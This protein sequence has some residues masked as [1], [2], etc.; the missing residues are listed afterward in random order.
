VI[1]VANT[2]V[3]VNG[4][5]VGNTGNGMNAA[6]TGK[7][8]IIGSPNDN[9][10]S[11]EWFTGDIDEVRLWNIALTQAQIKETI[12][13][14]PAANASGLVAWYSFNDGA[15]PGLTN[16][17]T[18][19]SGVDGTLASG[20]VWSNSPVQFSGNA[21]SLDGINDYAL[22]PWAAAHDLTN[23]VT[24]EAWVYP[25]NNNWDNILMKGNY[26]YGFALSGSGGAGSCGSSGTLVYW[27]QSQ[28]GNTIRSSL[29]YSLNTWQ[30]VAVTVEDIGSQLQIYF[31]LNGVQDGPYF[32]AATA[33]SNGGAGS[34]IYIGAQGL[35]LG[36]YFAGNLDELR[37]WNVVRPQSQ[38]QAAMNNELDPASQS[39]LVAYY[40]FNQGI[41]AGTNNGFSTIID[42]KGNNNAVLLNFALSGSSSNYVS[43]DNSVEI[44]PIRWQYFDAQKQGNGVLL[45]WA[46]SY[47]NNS[48]DYIVQH[49][50]DAGA[51]I[52]I[53]RVIAAGNSN[54]A[55]YYNFTHGTPVDGIN[56]YR[57]LETD[58]D[59][60]KA[61]SDIRSIKFVAGNIPFR[62]LVNPVTSGSLLLQVNVEGLF[63]LYNSDGILLWSRKMAAGNQTIEISGYTKGLYLLKSGG[64]LQKVVLH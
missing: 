48:K 37:L 30:H 13:K 2:A 51:W 49:S 61:Y 45:S 32:S 46:T 17:S 36:N 41:A 58:L 11:G 59:G 27:D 12:L 47:E 21:L 53:G 18:N 38:I 57:V 28:C 25:T 15:G 5:V 16:S 31:Y 6:A 39:N 1:T 44:L 50:T 63:T 10:V 64:Y 19:T 40:T 52:D 14:A 43:Q 34:S 24:I 3:Y 35:G 26:G 4:S 56:Y 20:P 8:L 54:N 55:S 62:I 7:P 29:T 22:V 23:T 42:Q 60:K 9:A 33:I